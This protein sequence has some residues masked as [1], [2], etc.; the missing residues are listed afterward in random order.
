VHREGGP[1]DNIGA[2]WT[3]TLEQKLGGHHTRSYPYLM[4][5]MA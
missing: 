5:A 3:W 1:D 2:Q 4:D